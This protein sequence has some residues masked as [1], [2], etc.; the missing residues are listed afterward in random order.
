MLILLLVHLG[1]A[2]AAPVAVR[3]LGLRAFYLLA[4]VPLSAALWAAANTAQVSAGG[5]VEWSVPWIRP[6]DF[7][8]ALRMDSLSWLMVLLVG[9]IGALVLVYCAGYFSPREPGLGQFAGVFVGFAGSM[10]GLVMSDDLLL[11]YVFWELTTVCSYLLIGHATTRRPSRRAALQALVVT[12]LGGLA[13]LAGFVMLG[14]SAGSYQWSEIA[15]ALP[16]GWYLAAAVIL[17]LVGALSKSA[18]FP[19]S[20]WLPAAMAAPTPVSAYLHAAAM[21]KAGVF[22]IAQ[23]APA[24]VLAGGPA[25]TSWHVVVLVA[26]VVTML[27][28]GIAALRQHDLKLLL[29]YGTV[30]QL[31]LLAVVLGIGRRDAALAGAVLLTADALSKAALFL[32]VGVVERMTG[33][34]D[35]R[36]LSGLYR[37][38]PWLAVA[39]GLAAASM[40]GFPPLVG[41]VAKEAVFASLLEAGA[42]GRVVLAGVAAGSVL[43]VA[44]SLR[45]LWGGFGS[46]AGVATE[47]AGAAAHGVAT[48]GAGAADQRGVPAGRPAGT[49]RR[50]LLASPL[51]LAVAGLVAGVAAPAVDRLL[52]PY[53]E[54]Y[55]AA[56]PISHLA[57]WHGPSLALGLSA[58]VL[59]LG[60]VWFRSSLPFDDGMSQPP[61]SVGQVLYYRLM[62]AVDRTAVAV[63]ARTQRGSLPFYLGVILVALIAAALAA[64]L[65]GGPFETTIRLWDTPL[66][67]LP[68]AVMI[69]AAIF[70][71]R[72][73]R[74]LTA[75]IL[76]GLTGYSLAG[77]FLLYGAPDLALTQFLVETVT[78][79]MVVLVLRRL[80]SHFSQRPTLQSRWGR[81]GLG[82]AVGAV[83]ASMTYVAVSARQAVP[84]SMGFPDLAVSYG[85]GHNIVNVILV[86]TRAWDTM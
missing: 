17:I 62:A 63:T 40:A 46:K 86:D 65:I 78:L 43:T 15:D 27:L 68:V 80:P 45:F 39:A 23:M 1:A 83:V 9:G 20:F 60:I 24:I 76:V 61:R 59:L 48:E 34:R 77:L 42:T 25:T 12:T 38:A 2:V 11:L 51:L 32:V 54:R 35:L 69:V 7:T 37:R 4:A 13:M 10:L 28:G 26:G 3:R 58:L 66:H 67:L 71:V 21:V 82:A 84:V 85:G 44:Y 52:S 22:L 16:G 31:G 74:R 72:A 50:I 41:F 47:G 64:F 18:I 56:G 30:S 70:A 33:T 14:E 49:T 81:I 55:A 73:L 53:A 19:F 5:A 75:V 29:A 79:V 36:R 8:L 6:L 57:L